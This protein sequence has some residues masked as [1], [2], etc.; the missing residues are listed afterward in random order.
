MAKSNPRGFL[1]QVCLHECPSSM[2]A[3]D[4]RKRDSNGIIECITAGTL[5]QLA[6]MSLELVRALERLVATR[7]T[8]C[9][10]LL[11]TVRPHVLG[12]VGALTKPFPTAG[13]FAHQRLV[14]GMGAHVYR[15]S[16]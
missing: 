6:H 1:M 7:D 11:C 3:M 8:A 12:Q 10:Q 16:C 13:K 9:I 14:S 15:Q 5:V 2:S 4:L